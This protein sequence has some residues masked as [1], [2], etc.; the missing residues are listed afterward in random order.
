MIAQWMEPYK[1]QRTM[2]NAII[3]VQ[4]NHSTLTPQLSA[5]LTNVEVPDSTFD[6]ANL[7]KVGK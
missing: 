5:P 1:T 7:K 3:D 2:C 4:L 6:L